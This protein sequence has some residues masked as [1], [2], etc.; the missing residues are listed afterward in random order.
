MTKQTVKTTTDQ[1]V[2]EYLN[3]RFK[4]KAIDE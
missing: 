2:N 3:K 1:I 4:T